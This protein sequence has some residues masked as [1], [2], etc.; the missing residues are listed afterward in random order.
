M[1]LFPYDEVVKEEPTQTAGRASHFRD[2][3]TE[4]RL[5]YASITFYKDLSNWPLPTLLLKEVTISKGSPFDTLIFSISL[6]VRRVAL[7]PLLSLSLLIL[8]SPV[9]LSGKEATVSHE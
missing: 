1:H 9:C 6:P 7:S 8:T 2:C 4:S 3:Y 5:A